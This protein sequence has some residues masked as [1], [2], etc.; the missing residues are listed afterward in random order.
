[1]ALYRFIRLINV[2]IRRCSRIHIGMRLAVIAGLALSLGY[3]A[4]LVGTPH[5][6]S[7]QDQ[8]MPME[9]MPTPLSVA[10]G[11]DQEVPPVVV[12]SLANGAGLFTVNAE[13]TE[14]TY[15]FTYNGPFSS[16]P[17]QVHLHV[18]RIGRTGPVIFFIC[19]SD[20]MTPAPAPDGVQACPGIA[21]GRLQGTL[22]EADFMPQID[23]GVETF[24]QAIDTLVSGNGYLNLHTPMNPSGEVRGQVGEIGLGAFL[25]SAAEVPPVEV[26]SE[27][28]GSAT[29]TMPP[30]R[31]AIS[32]ALTLDGALTGDVIAAHIHMGAE[33]EAGPVIFNLCPSPPAG[34]PPEDIE[35][36]VSR[37]GGTLEGT[38][39][40]TDLVQPMTG[41]I[42]FPDAI[43]ALISGNAY[44][45]VH[46][47]NNPGGEVRGQIQVALAAMLSSEEEEPPVEEPSEATGSAFWC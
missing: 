6:V 42:T 9:P 36:C 32:Y 39:V 16:P 40:E 19:A 20:R 4:Y 26:P 12:P 46:T 22:T 2:Q 43:D 29:V 25:S 1:M 5:P 23:A 10:A 45:N 18:G 38:L 15:D 17:Q 8:E 14:I 27:A 31:M 33:D 34:T 13:K 21:G 44:F 24:A 30:E 35:P 28:T 37:D 11:P 47:A 41:M 3:A 7:A